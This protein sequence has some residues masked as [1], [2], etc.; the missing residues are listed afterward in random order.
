MEVGAKRAMGRSIHKLSNR[1]CET[2]GPGRYVDGGG[3]YLVVSSKDARSWVFFWKMGGKRREMGLGSFRDVSLGRARELAAIARADRAAGHDPMVARDSRKAGTMTFGEAAD[4]FIES[5]EAGWANAKHRYQWRETLKT[6][7]A[8]LRA[9]PVS[10]ITTDDVVGVLKPLWLTKSETAGRLRGRIERVLD[11]AKARGHREGENPARWRGHLANLLPR[12]PRLSRGHHP[13]MPFAELPQFIAKLRSMT[14]VGRRALE[15]TILTAVRTNE[16]L[17]AK[18]TEIDFEQQVWVIPA[19]RMKAGKEH[20]VPL[21]H[22]AVA[23]LQELHELNVSPYA[24]PGLTRERPLSNLAMN[25]VLARAG[26]SPAIATVH[27]FRSSFRDWAGECTAF[28]REIAEAALAHQVG[29]ATERAYRRADA[30][31]KRR[32]L[33]AAWARYLETA[34]SGQGGA[35][36]PEP[37]TV[38]IQARSLAAEAVSNPEQQDILRGG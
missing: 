16:A 29:D 17:G 21:S 35:R 11:W 10:R 14:G 12:R 24:F 23:I 38:P 25:R 30:L 2:A 3:L 37:E 31:N 36:A 5:M 8:P 20:R 15:F 6:Y 26:I 32:E 18:W 1:K 27:G 34:G 9:I 28:P 33:M 22:R 7:A 4:K 19:G 13:A